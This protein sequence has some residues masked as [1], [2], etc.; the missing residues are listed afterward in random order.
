MTK[1][2]DLKISEK[3]VDEIKGRGFRISETWEQDGIA[4]TELNFY[5]DKGEDVIVALF[6]DN[7]DEGFIE[8][9]VRW[10]EE[11]DPEEHAV[12][13]Y[14][15]RERVYGVPQSLRALLYDADMI[16]NTVESLVISL[17]EC[18]KGQE[19]E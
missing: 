12:M 3:L 6:H 7:T 1:V 16:D 5:S 17:K 13:W 15:A 11:F 9:L 18:A 14:E 19:N 8:S 2:I 4:E 10:S